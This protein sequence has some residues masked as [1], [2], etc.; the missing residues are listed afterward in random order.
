[1][2]AP[3]SI[4]DQRALRDYLSNPNT[5]PPG[6]VPSGFKGQQTSIVAATAGIANTETVIVQ[7][8][9]EPNVTLQAGSIIRVFLGG[10][11]TSTVANTSTVNVYVGTTGT[12]ASDT[13]FFAFT[14]AAAGTSGTN[15]P[16][17]IQ[18]EGTVYTVGTAATGRIN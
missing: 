12:I 15:I 3:Y 4:A 11:S 14:T 1:M 9:V 17:Q 5:N 13:V 18:L 6:P 2:P 7:T 16:F 8:R 10:T